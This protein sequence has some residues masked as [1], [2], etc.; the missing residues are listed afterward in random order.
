M[1]L[2]DL[3]ELL[4]AGE[5]TVEQ[6]SLEVAAAHIRAQSSSSP[7]RDHGSSQGVVSS[8]P[9]IQKVGRQVPTKS[10]KQE[11]CARQVVSEKTHSLEHSRASSHEKEV[12]VKIEALVTEMPELGKEE[13]IKQE[14]HVKVQSQVKRAKSVKSVMKAPVKIEVPVKMEVVPEVGV[15]VSQEKKSKRVQV[16]DQGVIIPGVEVSATQGMIDHGVAKSTEMEVDRSKE[17]G[18]RSQSSTGSKQMSTGGGKE[19]FV[20]PLPC[21][22]IPVPKGADHSQMRTPVPVK[23]VMSSRQEEPVKQEAP[24]KVKDLAKTEAPVK[25]EDIWMEEIDAFGYVR[26]RQCGSSFPGSDGHCEEC[27]DYEAQTRVRCT[28]QEAV[29]M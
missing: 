8:L 11:R 23:N 25:R 21:P 1:V 27:E 29:Y 13:M 19:A 18:K 9:R 26:C 28:P 17:K 24:V 7:S 20:P 22:R 16:R 10:A 12:P 4:R 3:K 14:A 5:L 2:G 6:W 15:S